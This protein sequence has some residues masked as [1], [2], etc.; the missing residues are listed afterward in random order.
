M[1]KYNHKKIESKWQKQ[2]AKNKSFKALD[3][4]DKPKYYCLVEFPYPS[5]EGLHVGHVRSYTALDVMARKKRMQGFNVLY[6]IGWDAFGLPAENYAIKTGIHP[7]KIT[8]K[9]IARYKKQIQSLGISFDWDREINTTDPNYYKWT[10]WI[11]LKLF[12]NGLAYKKRMPINWCPSCKIGLANEEVV[13][14]KC[15][16]CGAISQRK[17]MEQWMLKITQ[18]ADRLIDDLQTVDYLEKI[19]TSQINWIGRSQGAQVTFQINEHDESV[20]VFTTRPD[21]L[22]G[23]TYLVLAPEHELVEKITT[24]EQQ[25]KV[26]DYKESAKRKSDLDR[27]QLNKEKTGVFT[28]AYAINPVN[29]QK[30]PVWIADYVL[31][32]YGTGAIM[33]VPA[34]DERDFD[35]A[36]KYNLPIVEVVVKK[37]NEINKQAERKDGVAGVLLNDKNQVYILRHQNGQYRL[38][39]GRYDNEENDHQTLIREIIEETGYLDFTIGQYLGAIQ[40]NFFIEPQNIYRYKLQKGYVVNLNSEK[41]Q[42]PQLEEFEDFTGQW[43]DLKKALD[44]FATNKESWGE[45]EFIKR[46]LEPETFCYAGDGININSGFLDGMETPQA[47][48]AI[49]DWLDKNKL[50]EEMV[51]YKLRDWV[52]SRQHYWG[53]PIPIVYCDHCGMVPL[54]EK[55]L[56]LKLPMVEKYEPTDNGES[57]LAAISGWVN[58]TCPKC[59]GPAK[60]ETDTMPNWAGSSWYFLRYCDPKDDK[61]LA[62]IDKLKY[63]MPVDL[64]NG[65]MEHTTLHL[66]YSRFWNKFLFDIGVVPF[67]EPYQRRVSHGMILAP[68]GEKMSKS[69]GNVIN[70]DDVIAEYGADVLRGYE[71]FIGPYDQAVGWDTNGIKGVRR[72][73][74]RNWNFDNFVE[75]ENLEVTSLL[76]K[77][78]IKVTQDI[79]DMHFNTAFSSLMIFLNK[80][81]DIGCS[82]DTFKKYLI[83]LSVFFP[84]ICEELLEKLGGDTLIALTDWPQVDQYLIQEEKII[85]PIQING[86][87]RDKIEVAPDSE[88]TEIKK[89]VLDREIVKKWLDGRAPKKVIYVKN[90]LVSIVL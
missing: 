70:P 80:I 17:E 72:F 7:T 62:P 83:L 39:A 58:T 36:K 81:N 88:E 49:I 1:S 53:E 9:N 79:D 86:K 82:R 14:G 89:S 50:G 52:F 13:E 22:F 3:K 37:F 38:P 18:Y 24:P 46:V 28:G 16:R 12:E 90:R 73:L 65:G 5:G 69:R 51:Q 54:P 71:M 15:E 19:K 85:L 87:M 57:P 8:K 10:Q 75:N 41:Q 33:A 67:N 40:A 43:V 61:N 25:S 55:E 48:N 35:F 27:T 20:I 47:K 4:S 11:F 21:T 42:A 63:W 84:H 77:T 78:I 59:G 26:Q 56:P 23:A 64:Y 74:E 45:E 60:R 32:S 68:D 44:L 76:Q 29:N 2:W 30:I 66:L 34:H 6:P 31:T